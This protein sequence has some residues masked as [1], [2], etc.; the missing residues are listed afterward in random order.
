MLD[1]PPE[2]SAGGQGA[3]GDAGHQQLHLQHPGGLPPNPAWGCCASRTLR[4]FAF[5]IPSGG[6]AGAKVSV[7]SPVSVP[8]LRG[9]SPHVEAGEVR[10][11]LGTVWRRFRTPQGASR[12]ISPATLQ[13]PA[14]GPP[15]L[16]LG[17]FQDQEC[18]DTG[19]RCR[20]GASA[21]LL[22]LMPLPWQAGMGQA[23]PPAPHPLLVLARGWQ[24]G[25]Q[26]GHPATG[27]GR[28]ASCIPHGCFFFFSFPNIKVQGSTKSWPW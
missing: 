15:T 14:P 24:P 26:G 1:L 4:S 19:C 2:C 22:S 13:D 9:S 11:V 21:R 18:A 7:P 23:H 25:P 16:G 27:C 10:M 20:M 28:K 17:I 5:R 12:G 8:I 3:E 6:S